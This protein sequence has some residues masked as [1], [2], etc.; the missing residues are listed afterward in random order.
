ME[1]RLY[2]V[3]MKPRAADVSGEPTF[4]M[5]TGRYPGLYVIASSFGEAIHKAEAAYREQ[6]VIGVEVIPENDKL[7]H[8]LR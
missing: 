6:V 2:Y 5:L 4:E 7:K 3:K 1:Q 8:I